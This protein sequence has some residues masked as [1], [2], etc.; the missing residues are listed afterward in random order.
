MQDPFSQ[1][2]EKD[3]SK[4][5]SNLLQVLDFLKSNQWLKG[6][7]SRVGEIDEEGG[8]EELMVVSTT[9]ASK[10]GKVV[11]MSVEESVV[12]VEE[13]EDVIMST[14]ELQ[15]PIVIVQDIQDIAE[16]KDTVDE[17]EA[18]SPSVEVSLEVENEHD[19]L[20]PTKEIPSLAETAVIPS[21]I[22][23]VDTL[24]PEF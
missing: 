5:I 10:V 15:E 11:E 8:V 16:A 23:P 20:P 21:K 13:L 12:E 18:N 6:V 7:E 19:T 24:N 22:I 1:L 14:E 17:E 3:I 2:A 9:T 4:I